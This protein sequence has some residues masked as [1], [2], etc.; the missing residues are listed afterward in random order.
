MVGDLSCPA[1][2]DTSVVDDPAG[3]FSTFGMACGDPLVHADRVLLGRDKPVSRVDHI[4]TQ[5]VLPDHHR[6]PVL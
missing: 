4:L 5:R 1:C 2:A 6:R 3:I